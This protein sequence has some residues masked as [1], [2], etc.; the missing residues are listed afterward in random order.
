MVEY[1]FGGKT[2]VVAF[3]QPGL[4]GHGCHAGSN[5]DVDFQSEASIIK[6]D[7]SQ[8]LGVLDLFQFLAIHGDV[9]AEV[10]QTVH[11]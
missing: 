7:S 3:P 8:V 2:D 10:I 9:Y 1:A 11:H 6:Q 4:C 5:Q